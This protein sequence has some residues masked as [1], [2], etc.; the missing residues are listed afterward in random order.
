M[1]EGVEDAVA[2]GSQAVELAP[3]VSELLFDFGVWGGVLQQ[4]V[5]FF[6]YLVAFFG[7]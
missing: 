2:P 4:Q 6:E 3:H 7:G 1:L 5:D